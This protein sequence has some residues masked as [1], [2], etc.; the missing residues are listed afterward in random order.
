L[1]HAVGLFA[2]LFGTWVIL[3]GHFT[4]FLLITG[5][6]CAAIT[7][8]ITLRMDL[9]DQRRD[10]LGPVWR[11]PFYWLWLAGQI[12]L[13][14]LIVARKVLAPRLNIDPI[15]E[16]VPSTQRSDLGR[17]IYANSITLTPGTC[18]TDVREGNI[19]VHALTHAAMKDLKSGDMDR[20]VT[21]TEA[22]PAK[23]SEPSGDGA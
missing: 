18:S 7:V 4:P 11:L 5:S 15:L 10:F 21:T 16:R 23:P 20:R 13:W 19:E 22:A 17:V 6:I 2:V 14:S 3:S 9:L 12:V 1:L 8:A